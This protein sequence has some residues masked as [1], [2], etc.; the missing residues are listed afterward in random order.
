MILPKL[1]AMKTIIRLFLL[2]CVFLG[3][4]PLPNA[5]AVNPPPDGGYPGGNTAEGQNALQSTTSGGFNSAVG[6]FSLFA[7][8]TGSFN[9]GVGAGALDLNTANNNTAIGAAA[10]LLN[11][12]GSNNTADGTDALVF[13][14]TGIQNTAT[15]AFALYGNTTGSGNIAVGYQAGSSLTSG[16]NNIDIG[17]IG[18]AAESN[19]IRIGDPAIHAGIFL[20]GITAMSPAA[21]NQA[22][23]VNPTTGQLGSADISSFGVVVTD[24]GEHRRWRS[25]TRFQYG[26]I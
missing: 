18:V 17:N 12:I 10:L 16:N 23:L 4:N 26:R 7:N 19:T 5:Q 25:G 8:T 3:A 2:V 6:Y 1:Q 20:A 13:N 14:N 24:P 9:T 21:P 15:G 11:T 22:V